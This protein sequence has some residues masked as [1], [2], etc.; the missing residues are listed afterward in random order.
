[1]DIGAALVEVRPHPPAEGHHSTLKGAGCEAGNSARDRSDFLVGDGMP[2]A[3][4]C[5]RASTIL[6]VSRRDEIS[7]SISG[8][9]SHH[10][11]EYL[12]HVLSPSPAASWQ[13]VIST[14]EARLCTS[15]AVGALRLEVFGMF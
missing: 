11:A 8:I 7:P 1:V 4:S 5:M 14:T 2:L 15:F 3:V 12:A 6:E 13:L 9:F 10:S